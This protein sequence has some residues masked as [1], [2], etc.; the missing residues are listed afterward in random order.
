MTTQCQSEQIP[1]SLS[2]PSSRI[3][4]DVC[5]DSKLN[6]SRR[7]ELTLKRTT[8]FSPARFRRPTSSSVRCLHLPSYP[9]R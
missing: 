2:I 9:C 6:P 5:S 4:P 7:D 3:L 8:D 1:Y